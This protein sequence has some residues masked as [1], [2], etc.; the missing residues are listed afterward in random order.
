[1]NDFLNYARMT[2]TAISALV[3]RTKDRIIA[4]ETRKGIAKLTRILRPQN[5]VSMK[6]KLDDISKFAADF[7]NTTSA[8]LTAEDIKSGKKGDF[9]TMN[10]LSWLEIVKETHVPHIPARVIARF[11]SEEMSL[12]SGIIEQDFI[13]KRPIFKQ[14]KNAYKENS[15]TAEETEASPDKESQDALKEALNETIISAMDSVSDHEMVGYSR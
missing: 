14:I 4:D 13:E 5:G 12:A 9:D 7:E 8:W 1:M 15:L 2:R 11:S 6:Q 10:L 3:L